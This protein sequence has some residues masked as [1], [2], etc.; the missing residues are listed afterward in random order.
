M[1][2]IAS[3]TT[4]IVTILVTAIIY[5]PGTSS[6]L[7]LDSLKLY[8]LERI[9][10]KSGLDI[11]LQDIKFGNNL[12]RYVSQAS[13]YLNIHA[14]SKLDSANIKRTNLAIHLAC[15]VLIFLFALNI[16][17]ATNY[18]PHKYTIAAITSSLWLLAPMNMS[19]VLYAVQRMTQLATLFSLA[20]LIL[21]LQSRK[22]FQS[23]AASHKGIMCALLSI[24]AFLL[25]IQSKE[26]G[27]LTI[28][29]LILIELLI[30]RVRPSSKFIFLGL[31]AC[32]IAA[33]A[34]LQFTQLPDYSEKPFTL[35]ER[36]LTQTVI[37]SEY[38]QNLILPTSIEIGIYQDNHTISKSLTDPI[39]TLFCTIA[40]AFITTACLFF[41][42][43]KSTSLPVFGVLFF[44]AG[45]LLESTILPIE[46]YFEHRNYA[47]SI[48]VYLTLSLLI[49]GCGLKYGIKI[50]ALF[51]S[52]YIAAF[53]T[54]DIL[55]VSNWNSPQRA[56]ELSA[57]KE[58]PSGRALSNL[59][60]LHLNKGD[61]S[62]A[63]K[64]LNYL[65]ES[66]PERRFSALLQSMYISCVTDI[67]PQ[68]QIYNQLTN[69]A[70]VYSKIE[71]S[72]AINNV[73]YAIEKTN[74]KSIDLNKLSDSLLTHSERT[75]LPASSSWYI[76]YY[77]AKIY[78]L[79][80]TTKAIDYL[81]Q[82]GLS[83]NDKALLFAEELI[84]TQQQDQ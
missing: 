36:L 45:H 44:F 26:T 51:L 13:F 83:G 5:I 37:V 18:S 57:Y 20:S 75:R 2:K 34:L 39:S 22:Y 8:Q 69:A 68:E 76:D 42:R 60:Q 15:G 38:M 48:G 27:V 50:P 12:G 11:S 23:K 53:I 6:P 64:T 52:V 10:N 29:Y 71:A 81:Y 31:A 70:S 58:P 56:L 65:I 7:Q 54:I 35:P 59:V 46:L 33:G 61:V 72:H 24:A 78:S 9:Y 67:P 47:P 3:I 62:R 30:F 1:Q 79:Q 84:K 74:C 4:L 43:F 55:K 66:V 63:R 32:I 77:I 16:S 14:S 41:S 28:T 17:G 25:A 40:I 82:L 21:Y 73:I 49:L 19:S 80:S